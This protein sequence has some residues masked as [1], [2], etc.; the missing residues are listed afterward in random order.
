VVGGD[1]IHVASLVGDAAK[2]IAAPDDDRHLNP[3]AVDVGQFGGDLMN[4]DGVDS[5]TLRSG[6]GFTGDFQENSFDFRIW[7]LKGDG[8]EIPGV[9]AF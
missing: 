8:D 5:E 7:I 6:K 4:A 9:M 1:A 2:E 3:E